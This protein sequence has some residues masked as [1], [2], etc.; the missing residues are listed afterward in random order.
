MVILIRNGREFY[1]DQSSGLVGEDRLIDQNGVAHETE[2]DI[3]GE[4]QSWWSIA[5]ECG[6]NE[7][8]A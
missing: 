1:W 5:L 3:V 2:T 7:A 8:P 6:E 4:Q